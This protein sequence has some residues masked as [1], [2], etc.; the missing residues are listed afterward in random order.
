MPLWSTLR[1]ISPLPA[2]S[3]L[4]WANFD[5]FPCIK[6]SA[7]FRQRQRAGNLFSTE[8]QAVSYCFSWSDYVSSC[9]TNRVD[10]CFRPHRVS[11]QVKLGSCAV[12]HCAC[13]HAGAHT[14]MHTPSVTVENP[15]LGYLET[16]VDFLMHISENLF[17]RARGP[18][19]A[20][21]GRLAPVTLTHMHKH[22]HKYTHM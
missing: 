12:L 1:P 9:Q 22:S 2:S 8:A 10:S 17:S 5:L 21:V 3:C 7:A 20:S 4:S 19:S 16:G 11:E 6:F 15:C 13:A 14:H 18:L